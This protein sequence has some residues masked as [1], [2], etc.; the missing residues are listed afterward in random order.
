ME[1]ASGHVVKYLSIYASL[2]YRV[3][4]KFKKMSSTGMVT[5]LSIGMKTKG[6]AQLIN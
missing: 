4:Q 1:Q 6:K 2:I 5:Q 3:P